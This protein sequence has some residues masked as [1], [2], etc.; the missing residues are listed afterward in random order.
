MLRVLHEA[1]A[2]INSP[3]LDGDTPLIW[4][5]Q[6]GQLITAGYL[7]D[8]GAEINTRDEVGMTALLWATFF[9]HLSLVSELL[10]R[11]ADKSVRSN[12]G[13]I[14]RTGLCASIKFSRHCASFR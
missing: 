4:A 2:D 5:A 7:L 13:I 6:T 9:N 10:D 14:A 8:S 1:G 11:K 12:Y 3:G